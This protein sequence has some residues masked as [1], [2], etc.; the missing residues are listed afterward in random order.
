MA[1]SVKI[2]GPDFSEGIVHCPWHHACFD[3]K[4]GEALKA[5]ALRPIPAWHVEQ[6]ERKVFVIDKKTPL[7]RPRLGTESQHFVIIGAGA[8]GTS[9]AVMLR[10][11]G[12]LGGIS[13][14]SEEKELPYDRME[15][16]GEVGK[17]SFAVAYYEDQRVAAMLTVGRDQENLM[18]EDALLHNDDKYVREIIKAQHLVKS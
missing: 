5:P 13:L 17:D 4:T 11:Q 15:V 9:A 2:T 6:R 3:L 8:A 7:L 18:V 14:V 10:R 16:F 12:F 1:F